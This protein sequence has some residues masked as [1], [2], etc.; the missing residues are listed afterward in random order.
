MLH[1][2]KMLPSKE[3]LEKQDHLHVIVARGT[4]LVQSAGGCEEEVRDKEGV[5]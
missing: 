2:A 5:L 4:T 3:I 1:K